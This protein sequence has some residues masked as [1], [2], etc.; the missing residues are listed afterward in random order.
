MEGN[1]E[2]ERM[3]RAITGDELDSAVYSQVQYNSDEFAQN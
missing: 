3:I 2:A 1:E